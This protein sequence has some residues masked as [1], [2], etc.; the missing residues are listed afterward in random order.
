MAIGT[1]DVH[2]DS[3][4]L[5]RLTLPGESPRTLSNAVSLWCHNY[6]VKLM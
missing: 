6:L 1:S 5:P 2:P 3:V 4:Q